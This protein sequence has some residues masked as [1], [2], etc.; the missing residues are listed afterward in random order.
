MAWY[1]YKR[2]RRFFGFMI[3]KGANHFA[4]DDE[5]KGGD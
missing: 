1:N 2:D 3:R 5:I 4:Q